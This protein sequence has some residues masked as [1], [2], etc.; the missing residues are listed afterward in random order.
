[1]SGIESV[2]R[3][4]GETARAA[5]GA[6][7]PSTDG[8]EARTAMVGASSASPASAPARRVT[9]EDATRISQELSDLSTSVTFAVDG[10]DGAVVVRVLDSKTKELIRQIPPEDLLVVRQ[11]MDNYLGMLTDEIA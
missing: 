6:V 11:R 3:A 4:S 7:T 2:S 5:D 8:K 10:K 9:S 1:M